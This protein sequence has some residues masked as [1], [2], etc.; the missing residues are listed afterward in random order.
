[1]NF[2]KNILGSKQ[3]AL[4][5]NENFWS[6]FRTRERVF[7]NVVKSH[8]NIEQDFFDELGPK[9]NELKE[10]YFYLTGMMNDDTAELVIT[11]DGN[12][13]NIV[14]AE[15]LVAQA[16]V[17]NGWKF[18]ALKEALNIE[19][20][21]IR[22]G[23]YEFNRKNL[24]FYANDLENY[25]DEIDITV[26]YDE[27]TKENENDISIGVY[28]FLENYL[29]E[30]N[31]ATIIDRLT[32]IR[33]DQA[34]K[35]LIPIEKL[36]S[37]LIWREKEFIEKYEDIRSNADH[38]A[39][40]M[41]EAQLENGNPLLAIINTELLGW[42]SK[43]SHPWILNYTIKFDGENTNG[44]PDQ[45]TY[46]LLDN[47]EDELVSHLKDVEGYLNIGRETANGNREIYFACKEFR[48]PSKVAWKIQEKYSDQLE[49]SYEIFKDKY[50]QSFKHFLP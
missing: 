29:G 26:L 7:F 17:L 47:I 3:Q 31:A 44:M 9:L 11:A 20:V 39:Y 22:M 35:E 48:K 34:K 23:E 16:P 38:D 43:A 6:W 36:K 41:L 25:P 13:K 5:S 8:Q 21:N 32:I 14:F 50:W 12:I 2:L 33:K 37:F 28:I 30:L 49:I 15:E 46:K 40:S 27:L 18:T 45:H 19:D 1:M 42:D 4:K 24:Q 10:G